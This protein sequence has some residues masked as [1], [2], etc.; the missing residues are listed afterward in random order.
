MGVRGCFAIALAIA[1]VFATLLVLGVV[2]GWSQVTMG[3][4]CGPRI[5]RFEE[6]KTIRVYHAGR[7]YIVGFKAYVRQVMARG[8]WPAHHKR[9]TLR[10]GAQATKQYAWYNVKHWRGYVSGGRC[11]HVYSDTRDQLWSP[12]RTRYPVRASQRKA[13]NA[14][15]GLSLAKYRSGRNHWF[16]TSY[17]A[18]HS[19]R[20]GADAN[21]WKLYA[22]G[23]AK[24]AREGRSYKYILKRYYKNAV[25]SWA[26]G[27]G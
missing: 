26:P 15:W 13:V 9:A 10:A 3:A 11:F 24:C 14:V 17:R 7:V 16:A 4:S 2:L 27:R 6:P 18:G 19:Q 23:A 1:L 22:G 12:D 8:E 21:G 20:C 5:T 25:L